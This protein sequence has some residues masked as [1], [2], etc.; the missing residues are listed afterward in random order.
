MNIFQMMK[1]LKSLQ[2]M[3]KNFKE[4]LEKEIITY[5]DETCKLVANAA[6]KVL[7]IK[8]KTSDCKDL[9]EKLLKAFNELHKLT[10]E[11]VK[12]KMDNSLLGG[13]GF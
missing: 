13:F 6:G 2:D 11:R 9:E 10:K 7:E 4:D 1:Q 3:V 8:I 12:E 5:E